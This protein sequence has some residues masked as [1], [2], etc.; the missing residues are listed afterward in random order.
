MSGINDFV[1]I[2]GTAEEL[3]FESIALPDSTFYMEK[4]STDYP[5]TPDGYPLIAAAAMMKAEQIAET[6]ARLK[7]LLADAGRTDDPRFAE[8]YIHSGWQQ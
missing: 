7:V 8:T 6:I 3:G 2:A 4:R 1:E 5:Y